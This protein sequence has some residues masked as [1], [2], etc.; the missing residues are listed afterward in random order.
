MECTLKAFQSVPRYFVYYEQ[1]KRLLQFDP[2][3]AL[4]ATNHKLMQG[5]K[6][7]DSP[8]R[9]TWSEFLAEPVPLTLCMIN[10]FYALGW[11]DTAFI[12][13]V[14]LFPFLL[15]FVHAAYEKYTKVK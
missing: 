14:I 15:A 8:I 4:Y 12:L 5:P 2:K 3:A 6:Q 9:H 10:I 7:Q 13:L 1:V 11:E